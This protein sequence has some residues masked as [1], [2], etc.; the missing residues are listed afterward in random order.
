MQEIKTND[1]VIFKHAYPVC[2][3]LIDEA[4]WQELVGLTEN[5]DGLNNTL[6]EMDIYSM[7]MLTLTRDNLDQVLELGETLRNRADLFTFNRISL[8]GEG[9]NLVMA[10]PAGYPAF[11]KQYT[12]AVADNPCLGVK[13]N[14]LNI[15]YQHDGQSLFGGCIGHGCGAAFNFI[16]VLA[17]GEV[18]ACRKFPSPLGNLMDQ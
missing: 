7:I 6:R 16:S 14:L 15:V 9:A 1:I 2:C 8:V 10:D 12:D 11:L 18:H 17:N 13:D 4:V 5:L 3:S